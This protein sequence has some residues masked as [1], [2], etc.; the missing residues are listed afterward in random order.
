[1]GY[2]VVTLDGQSATLSGGGDGSVRI[3]H[4][5]EVSAV[6]IRQEIYL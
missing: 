1:M 6:L 2:Y 4:D 3:H 5:L